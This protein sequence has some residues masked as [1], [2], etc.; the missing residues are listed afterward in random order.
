[1]IGH[2]EHPEASYKFIEGAS[3]IDFAVILAE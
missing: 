2:V 1:M 3:K